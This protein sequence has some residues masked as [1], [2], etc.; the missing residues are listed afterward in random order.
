MKIRLNEESS[1]IRFLNAT[2]N[3][4]QIEIYMNDNIV[5]KDVDYK[6]FTSYIP[7]IP[8]NYIVRVYESENKEDIL[9]E[10]DIT[11]AKGNIATLVL[12]GMTPKL[13]MFA[14]FEDPNELVG[15]GNSKFRIA[16]LSPT[17]LPIDLIVNNVKMIDEIPFG[18]RT[19]YAEV[20]SGLYNFVV[21]ESEIDMDLNETKAQIS[22]KV[23]IKNG[24]IYTIYVVGDSPSLEMVQSLDVTTFI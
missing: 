11:I 19:N 24:K 18:K 14:V 17:S 4:N 23:E 5:F 21:K 10:Q 13:I 22:N 8:G 12:S 7:T 1:Y 15:E 3:S 20:P 9:L 16:N 2:P 6:E